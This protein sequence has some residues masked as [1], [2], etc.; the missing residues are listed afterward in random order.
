MILKCN[1]HKK[2]TDSKVETFPTEA[3]GDYERGRGDA[4][5]ALL[6]GRIDLKNRE[7]AG[8]GLAKGSR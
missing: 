8:N 3:A 2:S 5:E 6:R 1:S 4:V 7:E